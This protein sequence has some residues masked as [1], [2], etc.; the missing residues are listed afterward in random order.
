MSKILNFVLNL[1]KKSE[2]VVYL[3]I[4]LWS[5]VFLSVSYHKITCEWI[6]TDYDSW[7]CVMPN[8]IIFNEIIISLFYFI[9]INNFI[10]FIKKTNGYLITRSLN[11]QHKCDIFPKL[12]S[13]KWEKFS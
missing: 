3:K 13:T 1:I 11:V 4:G 12:K 7:C 2:F 10:Q 8:D 6:S 5:G 9:W